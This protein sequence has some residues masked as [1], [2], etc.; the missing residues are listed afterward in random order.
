MS[1]FD[2]KQPDLE[3]P[4]TTERRFNIL[5]GRVP[6]DLAQ[7][8]DNSCAAFITDPPYCTGANKVARMR[9]AS[10]KYGDKQAFE[11]QAARRGGIY[12]FVGDNKSELVQRKFTI[13][14][15]EAMHHICGT[16]SHGF[17]FTDWRG[18]RM[19]EEACAY[20]GY[21]INDVLIFEKNVGRTK[22]WGWQ[23]RYEC[24][25]QVAS[26][27]AAFVDVPADKIFYGRS[28]VLRYTVVPF[29]TKLHQVQ[30]P[31][32]LIQEL[33]QCVREPGVIIDPFAGSGSTLIAAMLSGRDA[34]GFE[35]VKGMADAARAECR[36]VGTE[37]E[38]LCK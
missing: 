23:K 24:I 19:Y 25:L 14:W 27:G 16:N 18:H 5:D 37:D 9:T 22:P 38:T 13:D 1:R 31:V 7:I 21:V 2:T 36:S 4:A 3:L 34:I 20:S 10:R 28:S 8:K 15:L 17:I 35:C 32:P 26:E 33:L 29:D 12:G 11:N 6:Q 30:K